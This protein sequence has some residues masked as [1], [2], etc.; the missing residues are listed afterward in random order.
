MNLIYK[1]T[2]KHYRYNFLHRVHPPT[3]KKRKGRVIDPPFMFVANTYY[4]FFRF[5]S[6]CARNSLRR[7]FPTFVLGSS[8]LNST[9]EGSL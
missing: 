4:Y 9:S 8:V 2:L 3:N 1:Q 6:S 5:S 7:I